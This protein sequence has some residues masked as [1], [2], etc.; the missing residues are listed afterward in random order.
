MAAQNVINIM[1][2]TLLN[3]R[4][5]MSAFDILFKNMMKGS[6]DFNPFWPGEKKL[7]SHPLNARIDSD[8]GLIFEIA[9]TGIPREE[10][11][12]HVGNRMHHVEYKNE[13]ASE[14]GLPTTDDYLHRG[15]STKAFKLGWKISD[16]FDLDLL[17]ASY[18]DGLLTLT[19]PYSNQ[20]SD[21]R[22][23]EL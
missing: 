18:N 17:D 12:V 4:T 21:L 8:R 9:C 7:V 11:D 1:T 19:I 5:Q 13:H 23:I 6:S 2:Q 20:K 15:L 22:K 3:P 14:N 10:I 16:K